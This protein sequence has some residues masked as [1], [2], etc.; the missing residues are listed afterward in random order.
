V[1]AHQATSEQEEREGL[2]RGAAEGQRADGKR[3]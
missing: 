1:C 2:K 3:V